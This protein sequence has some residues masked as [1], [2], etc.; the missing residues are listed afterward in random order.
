[1]Q[2]NFSFN[3]DG[4]FWLLSEQRFSLRFIAFEIFGLAWHKSLMH[5]Y[6]VPW[7]YPLL[8]RHCLIEAWFLNSF[9][10]VR[11]CLGILLLESLLDVTT[12]F[13]KKTY[14]KAG[15]HCRLYNHSCLIYTVTP[16]SITTKAF[17][18]ALAA[19]ISI[20]NILM[21]A[22]GGAHI[23]ISSHRWKALPSCKPQQPSPIMCV[24][25]CPSLDWFQ[26]ALH[27][28]TVCIQITTETSIPYNFAFLR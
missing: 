18:S 13:Q 15:W 26:D 10:A 2:G 7:R 9:L 27:Y 24:N 5:C 23:C 20:T 14:H 19:V 1:M 8:Q 21:F 28:Y 3:A 12:S 6:N 17:V 25:C 22:L 16:R 4:W 11:M